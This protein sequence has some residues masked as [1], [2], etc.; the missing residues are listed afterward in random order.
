MWE[1]QGRGL[2]HQLRSSCVESNIIA[3]C[4]ILKYMSELHYVFPD[5]LILVYNQETPGVDQGC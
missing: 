4:V 3:Y 2:N 5:D 1:N